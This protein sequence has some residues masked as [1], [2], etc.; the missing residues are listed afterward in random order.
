MTKNRITKEVTIKLESGKEV[1]LSSKVRDLIEGLV[2]T[3]KSVQEVALDQGW[4]GEAGRQNAYSS[5]STLSAKAYLKEKM[6]SKYSLQAP[7]ALHNIE[8]LSDTARS[9]FVKL[10]AS[11]DILDRAGFAPVTQIQSQVLG[12]FKVK[13]DLS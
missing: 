2:S 1:K 10:Q 3:G 4:I 6:Y 7:K 11:Q 5:L 9:E 12:D 13:I 8:T